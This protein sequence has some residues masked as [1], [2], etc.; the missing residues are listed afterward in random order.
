MDSPMLLPDTSRVRALLTF[1]RLIPALRAAFV[2][3][4]TVPLRHTHTMGQDADAGISLLMPAWNAAGYYGVKIVNIFPGNTA[5]SLPGLHSSYLLHDGRTGVPVALIDGNEI[6]SRRTA[7]ASALAASYLARDD[8]SR[9]LVVGAGRVGSLVAPAMASVRQLQAIEVWDLN[10]D[11]ANSCAESLRQQ[12]L[13][14]QATLDLETAVRRADIVSCATL[15]TTPVIQ[16]EWLAAGSHLDLIGSFN[17][18]MTEATPQCFAQAE[19]WVD[20]EEAPAKSGDLLNAIAAGALTQGDIAGD[21][22]GLCRGTCRTRGDA[23]QR[24]VFKAVGTALEDLA[25]AVLVYRELTA[26]KD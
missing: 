26:K 22:Q 17:P 5:K 21:L 20:T 25:A 6:T 4:A 12:G 2:E 15:A 13:P 8:A 10:P 9:L 1:D 19:V 16:A 7:A 11:T 24:T 3:G 23:A 14:A 18:Q